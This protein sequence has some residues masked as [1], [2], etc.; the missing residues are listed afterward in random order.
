VLSQQ[1]EP[2]RDIDKQA[3]EKDLSRAARGLYSRRSSDWKI[4]RLARPP[5]NAERQSGLLDRGV[6]F[7][8]WSHEPFELLP[9]TWFAIVLREGES[10]VLFRSGV[11]STTIPPTTLSFNI[12]ASI[13]GTVV[14][15]RWPSPRRIVTRG[16]R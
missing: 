8:Q 10:V 7:R 16:A 9:S 12:A 15:K 6:E 1:F 4:T 2:I 13:G 5:I 3:V 11:R 14:V